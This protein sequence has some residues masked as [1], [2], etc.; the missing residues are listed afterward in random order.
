LLQTSLLGVA[1]ERGLVPNWDRTF[2]NGT[3]HIAHF[4]IYL[5]K[6]PRPN[7]S[8]MDC[9]ILIRNKTNIAFCWRGGVVQMRNEL[10]EGPAM[11][12]RT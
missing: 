7:K 6:N 10:K 8:S 11:A 4:V 9:G 3:S 5:Y 2:Q 1:I 12:Y